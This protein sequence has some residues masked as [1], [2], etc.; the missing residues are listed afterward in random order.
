MKRN[1]KKNDGKGKTKSVINSFT[2]F[3]LLTH[4]FTLLLIYHQFIINF[5]IYIKKYYI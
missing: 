3:L 1:R 4:L 2:G 5:R